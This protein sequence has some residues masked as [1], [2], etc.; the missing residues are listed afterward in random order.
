MEC[1]EAREIYDQSSI[2]VFWG[3]LSAAMLRMDC[4]VQSRDGGWGSS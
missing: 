4:S 1:F 2:L 3:A